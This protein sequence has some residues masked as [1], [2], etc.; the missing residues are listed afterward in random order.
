MKILPEF[1]E[2][3]KIAE[4]GQYNVVPISCEILSDFTTPIETMKI[5]KNVSTHCYMLESAVADEQWG[6]Y[7]FLGFAPK[8]EITCIDG[9][10]QIGNVKIETENPSEHIRQILADYKSPRFAYLP[11]FTGGLVGYFSYDYLGYSEPSVRCRVEDSEAFKDVDL[12]LFDKVIAFDHVRQKIILIVN[13]SLDDIEV[14][15][16]KAVLELKQLVELLKK[17]EKKQETKGCLMGEVIP[18]FEKEQFCGMVEQAKQYIR[19]GDIFQIVLSN[20]LSAPF[21]GSLLNTYRM[22]RT[23]NPS[24]YMF[25]FSG[26]DVEVAGASPETLVKLENGILHTFPLA[27]TRP[28]GKTNEEDRALS[29]ELLADEKELAEHNML[30]DL[31]RND[32]GKISR[33][34][35][36]KVEKF[37]TIEYFSHVMHIGSTVR[38]E[39]CKGKDALDAIEAVLPAG[40]LSGAPKIRACQLIGELENNKRGIYGGAIGYIDFTGNMDTCI[41]IRIAYKKNGKVFVRSGAGIVADSVPEKEYTECINKAK[42][43]VDALKLAEEGEI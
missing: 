9:E 12:M 7:T 33:F 31:G 38:G 43:V 1:R 20:R 18:L 28:R 26:T 13:M 30:V 39:I 4:S 35:T 41:A 17:G 32:L 21:E 10:M 8:L 2:V 37:H 15:Y 5:L 29:Q 11:S 36:V 40:T 42:A 24:P 6:R 23:I 27:G 14:G 34:G 25:Y 16:N 19:E 3:K 22:L